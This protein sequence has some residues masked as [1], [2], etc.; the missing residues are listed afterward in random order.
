MVE[1]PDYV[2]CYLQ[3]GWKKHYERFLL[4]RE[5]CKDLPRYA[6][7]LRII[8]ARLTI[9]R[10]LLKIT[11]AQQLTIEKDQLG[12]PMPSGVTESP[13]P[14]FPTPGG[15]IKKI[16]S[17]ERAAMLRRLHPEYVHLCSFTHGMA[18]SNFFKTVFNKRLRYRGL[19]PQSEALDVF[20]KEIVSES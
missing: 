4:Q 13:I 6:E 12:T 7:Y 10:D 18:A 3:D 5:E 16:T 17:P 2:D 9:L 1:S 15:L 20:N 8:P 14:S 19:M 11:E